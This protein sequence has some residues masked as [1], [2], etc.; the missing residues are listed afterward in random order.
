MEFQG[1]EFRLT[2]QSPAVL[3]EDYGLNQRDKIL[4]SRQAD[5]K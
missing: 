4:S 3:Q 2:W 1:K 5:K